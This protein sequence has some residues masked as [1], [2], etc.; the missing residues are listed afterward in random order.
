[1]ATTFS[2]TQGSP[3]GP[4]S[5]RLQHSSPLD[6]LVRKSSAKRSQGRRSSTSSS[7]QYPAHV[8]DEYVD[9]E[10]QK[11]EDPYDGYSQEV[12]IPS[13]QYL[14]ERQPQ[15]PISPLLHG[16]FARSSITTASLNGSYADTRTSIDSRSAY[17]GSEYPYPD[18]ESVHSQ[19]DS[20]IRDSWRSGI[21]SETTRPYDPNLPPNNSILGQG[22]RPPTAPSQTVSGSMTTMP[23]VVVS[24]ADADMAQSTQQ[25]TADDVQRPGRTPVMGSI[26]SNFSRP[27]RSS[28]AQTSAL[29]P[30]QVAAPPPLPPDSEEQKRRVLER[31]ANRTPSRSPSRSPQNQ[32]RKFAVRS[33]SPFNPYLNAVG[34]PTSSDSL[35][36][37]GNHQPAPKPPLQS[38]DPTRLGTPPSLSPGFRADPRF[39]QSQATQTASGSN[40]RLHL[41]PVALPRLP[42]ERSDSPASLY[43]AYS[44][45]NFES[46]ISS[47]AGS[48]F[49]S[50]RTSHMQQSASQQQSSTMHSQQH[51]KS[52]SGEHPSP[53]VPL[54][55]QTPHDFLSLGIQNHEANRLKESAMYFEK[56]AKE[57]G[58]CGVGMLMWGLTLRHGWGCEKNEKVGFKW[59]RKAAEHA[60]V[61]LESA[62]KGQ[63]V[64]TGSVEVSDCP[65]VSPECCNSPKLE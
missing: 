53:P 36:N 55:S 13:P 57:G 8:L 35:P 59:L 65:F 48:E 30:Q 23:T 40:T 45:Y 41:T 44:Y 7:Q 49:S 34:A 42:P 18:A 19:N 2:L 14:S 54:E 56:S 38:Y 46:A 52:P 12:K 29:A 37:P 61:D 10:V 21:S 1:M 25:S 60:V 17:Q 20:A 31:N 63:S 9:P 6:T 5:F 62:R 50:P 15:S 28:L 33:K 11:G 47:P 16:R 3:A 24:S 58:G 26:T 4:T 51:S 39:S 27:M 64:D 32:Q 43:S 22:L